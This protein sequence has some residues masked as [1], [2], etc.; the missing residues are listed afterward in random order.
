QYVEPAECRNGRIDQLSADV[1]VTDIAS[2]R[3]GAPTIGFDPFHRCLRP[4]RVQIGAN[5]SCAFRCHEQ[6]DGTTDTDI[7]PFRSSAGDDRHFPARRS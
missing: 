5:K 3:N 1:R 7:I 2:S 6:G 4:R